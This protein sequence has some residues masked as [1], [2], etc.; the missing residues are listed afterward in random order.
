VYASLLRNDIVPSRFVNEKHDG[1]LHV[2][3]LRRRYVNA[4]ID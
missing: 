3:Q 2:W 4:F 1:R